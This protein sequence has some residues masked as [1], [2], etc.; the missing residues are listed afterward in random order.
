MFYIYTVRDRIPTGGIEPRT[1]QHG[2]N[3]PGESNASLSVLVVR[4]GPMNRHIACQETR[5]DRHTSSSMITSSILQFQVLHLG[6]NSSCL[7]SKPE[8]IAGG[9]GYDPLWSNFNFA[10][11]T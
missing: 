3:V 4:D 2:S 6:E 10:S 8:F 11:T 7:F 9:S 5:Q 1:H